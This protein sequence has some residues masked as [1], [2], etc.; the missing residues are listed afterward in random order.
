MS[1]ILR[2]METPAATP[3]HSADFS[4]RTDLQLEVEASLAYS[5][6]LDSFSMTSQRAHTLAAPIRAELLVVMRIHGDARLAAAE[7]PGCAERLRTVVAWSGRATTRNNGMAMAAAEAF[8]GRIDR[9]LARCGGLVE[10]AID[11]LPDVTVTGPLPARRVHIAKREKPASRLV[12]PHVEHFASSLWVE[13]PSIFQIGPGLRSLRLSIALSDQHGEHGPAMLGAI[14]RQSPKLTTLVTG[15]A[16]DDLIPVAVEAVVQSGSAVRWWDIAY[17]FV[18]NHMPNHLR[19][20]GQTMPRTVA[21]LS[22]RITTHDAPCQGG[23]V[24]FLDGLAS[25]ATPPTGL[26]HFALYLRSHRPGHDVELTPL[27]LDV[28]AAIERTRNLGVQVDVVQL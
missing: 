2:A 11:W 18:S 12:M 21:H 23:A 1:S 28:L 26:R 15:F 13:S 6:D 27:G 9:L 10:M 14:L 5:H 8:I 20:A 17:D 24:G 19:A 25:R 4:F 22:L 7:Q 3:D 16:V